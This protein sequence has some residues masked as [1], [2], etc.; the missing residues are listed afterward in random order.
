MLKVQRLSVLCQWG[1]PIW[2]HC[3]TP[4]PRVLAGGVTL[5]AVVSDVNALQFVNRLTL[6]MIKQAFFRLV[7]QMLYTNLLQR[8]VSSWPDKGNRTTSQLRVA[9][10]RTKRNI[11]RLQ[12]DEDY[13]SASTKNYNPRLQLSSHYRLSYVE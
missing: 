2:L 9:I 1:M 6:R 7:S 12:S 4:L 8:K 10:N 11:H 3:D 5:Q 13:T